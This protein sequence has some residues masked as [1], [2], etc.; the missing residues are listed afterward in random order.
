MCPQQSLPCSVVCLKLEWRL[1]GAGSCDFPVG[2][3]GQ[4][5][6]WQVLPHPHPHPAGSLET[7]PPFLLEMEAKRKSWPPPASLNWGTASLPAPP[8]W[9]G[10]AEAESILS[11]E[12]RGSGLWM[13]EPACPALG[14]VTQREEWGFAGGGAGGPLREEPTFSLSSALILCKLMEVLSPIIHFKADF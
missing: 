10:E 13:L 2:G 7:L 6:C 3:S 14:S 4:R 1:A 11:Q 12:K 9:R 5:S 8:P